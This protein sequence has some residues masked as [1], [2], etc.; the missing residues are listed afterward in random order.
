M[1]LCIPLMK[2]HYMFIFS[3]DTPI[4]TCDK[5]TKDR[6]YDSLPSALCSVLWQDKLVMLD[7]F[8]V[9]VGIN[10]AIWDGV[11]GKHGTGNANSS[12]LR[13]LTMC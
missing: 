13:L 8:N 3:V 6:S 1:T 10:H 4:L 5:A 9:R 11:I 2:N 7:D 12:D